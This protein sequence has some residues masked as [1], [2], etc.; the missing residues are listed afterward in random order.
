MT[1]SE[2]HHHAEQ[3]EAARVEFGSVWK[4]FL[5]AH[6]EILTGCP[7][8]AVFIVAERDCWFTFLAGKGLLK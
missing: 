6:P 8:P 7:N 4:Q 3:M 1:E 5:E 2:Y